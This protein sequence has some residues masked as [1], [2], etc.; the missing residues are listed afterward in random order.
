MKRQILVSLILLSS[1]LTTNAQ[2]YTPGNTIQGNS[3]NNFIGIGTPTPGRNLDVNGTIRIQSGNGFEF[4][5]AGD[6]AYGYSIWSDGAGHFNLGQ[7]S[8]ANLRQNIHLFI[9]ANTSFVGLGTTTPEKKLDVEGAVRVKSGNSFEFLRA[10]DNAYGYSIWSDGAGHFNLGQG[11]AAN[12]RQNIHLFINANTS[13]VGV[14]TTTPAY[15]LD[16]C[17][18]IRAKEVKVDLQG[19]CDFVFESN[20]KL[21]DLKTLEHF[22]KTKQ[23]L[24][25]IASEKEMIEN[26][27]NMKE[28]QMKL[29][30][31]IEELTLY[32]IEQNKELQ[33]MKEKIAK[34]ETASK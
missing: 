32:T 29:L 27:V 25:E 33:I 3:N 30:Q 10:G 18:T 23:H 28:L 4:L 7:G 2:I 19:G 12:L 24:P 1:N 13:F 22:V 34:L 17:G 31:K 6:N 8:A 26:G 16:V 15:K 9:N 20:Y 21:M 14:G 11:S 5:R